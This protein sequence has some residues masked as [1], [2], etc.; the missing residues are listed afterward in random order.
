MMSGREHDDILPWGHWMRVKPGTGSTILVDEDGREWNSLREALFH[1][2][3]G[4]RDVSSFFREAELERML[5]YLLAAGGLLRDGRHRY[6]GIELL[7]D[8]QFRMFYP[9]WL[10]SQGLLQGDDHRPPVHERILTKEGHSIARMLLVT[11]PPELAPFHPGVESVLFALGKAEEIRRPAF[12]RGDQDL[13]QM[14]FAFVRERIGRAPAI[15]LLHRDRR[16]RMPL[17]CT[18]WVQTFLDERSRDR[19][20][21]WLSRRMDRWNDWGGIARSTSSTA[22]TQKL[23]SLFACEMD[24]AAEDA[25]DD[26]PP[27][28]RDE[29]QT[30]PLLSIEYRGS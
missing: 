20:F 2:R 8:D 27:N 30:P 23:F 6:A 26:R 14:K 28:K 29:G 22:L 4:F 7:E 21:A 15:S 13:G 9:H 17:V 1:G 16:T 25:H 24:D 11:R 3:L 12:E 5:A 18:I 19:Y 10:A